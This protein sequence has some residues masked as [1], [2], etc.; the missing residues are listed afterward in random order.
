MQRFFPILNVLFFVTVGLGYIF[1]AFP[2]MENRWASY[3]ATEEV[4]ATEAEPLLV[5]RHFAA[6][7]CAFM[8]NLN[9]F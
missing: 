5:C 6:D 8:I 4:V 1:I 3:L 2:W 9:E 7:P